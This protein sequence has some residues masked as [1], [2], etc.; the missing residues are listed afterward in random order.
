MSADN[1][2]T[3]LRTLPTSFHCYSISLL[4]ADTFLVS[5]Y[6]HK[7]P[8]RTVDIN[9]KEGDI[10]HKHLPDKI[11]E[12]GKSACAYIQ[13]SNTIVFSDRTQHTLYMCDT[14]SGEGRL[15]KSDKIANARCICAGPSGSTFVCCTDTN[16]I[17]KFS[18][19]GDMQILHDV[20]IRVPLAVSVSEDG[21]RMAVSSRHERQAVLK[22]FLI[23]C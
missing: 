5:T 21:T 12:R 8:V 11:Y 17:L 18:P 7:R 15:I 16:L 22:L 20:G 2:I 4:N 14:T 13:S 6:G 9:G 23:E 19:R 1:S 10:Q 3:L